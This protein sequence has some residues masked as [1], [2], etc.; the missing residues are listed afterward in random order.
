MKRSQ[1]KKEVLKHLKTY[2][3]CKLNTINAEEIIKICEKYMKPIAYKTKKL[4][5]PGIY[6]ERYVNEWECE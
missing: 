6:A 1:L 5:G 4:L 3:N 2:D